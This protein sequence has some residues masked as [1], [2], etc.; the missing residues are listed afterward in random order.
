[1]PL[2]RRVTSTETDVAVAA[3]DEDD[4]DEAVTL[5]LAVGP[6]EVV[7]ALTAALTDTYSKVVKL[8]PAPKGKRAV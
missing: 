6:P 1:V 7:P 2:L 5:V 3:D 8:N 4:E